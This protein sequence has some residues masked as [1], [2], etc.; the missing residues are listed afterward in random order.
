MHQCYIILPWN[1]KTIT[2]QLIS[3]LNGP[4]AFHERWCRVWRHWAFQLHISLRLTGV[5]VTAT[6]DPTAL[7]PGLVRREEWHTINTRGP[8]VW[9]WVVQ[10]DVTSDHRETRLAELNQSQ[11]KSLIWS[12]NTAATTTAAGPQGE[13]NDVFLITANISTIQL[14]SYLC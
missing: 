9:C 13:M 2:Q 5:L 10:F 6:P 3:T 14:Q 1:V 4:E 11:L 12:P 7:E 8:T